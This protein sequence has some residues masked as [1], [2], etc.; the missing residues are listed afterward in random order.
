MQ[1]VLTVSSKS[2]LWCA[3]AVL[4][5][6]GVCHCLRVERWNSSHLVQGGRESN[7]QLI[8]IDYL[9]SRDA[10]LRQRYLLKGRDDNSRV[11]LTESKP[12]FVLK[13]GP[14]L[15][16]KTFSAITCRL[17]VHQISKIRP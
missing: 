4:S 10:T 13:K 1:P 6:C 11:A 14:I 8:V 12:I 7:T 2:V 16:G 3:C 15:L 9:R 5:D 17:I